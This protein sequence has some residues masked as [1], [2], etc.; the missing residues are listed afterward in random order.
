MDFFPTGPFPSRADLS[1]GLRPGMLTS[2]ECEPGKFNKRAGLFPEPLR[3][4]PPLQPRGVGLG[5]TRPA[6]GN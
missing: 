5:L 1:K 6:S 3:P 2:V 4:P